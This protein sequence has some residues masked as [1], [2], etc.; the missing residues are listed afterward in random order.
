MASIDDVQDFNS[1]DLEFEDNPNPAR[2][3]GQASIKRL[4]QD[5]ERDRI[6]SKKTVKQ[7]QNQGFAPS[8]TYAQLLWNQRFK[9]YRTHV[10]R[11]SK[12]TP[13]TGDDLIRFFDSIIGKSSH[14]HI[15]EYPCSR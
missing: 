3:Y 15:R 14:I 7:L 1:S 13:F 5:A 8:T 10:L 2:V 12:D 4:I 6:G 9:A 11:Q